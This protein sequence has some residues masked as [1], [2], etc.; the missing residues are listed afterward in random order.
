MIGT[1]AAL[2]AGIVGTVGKMVERARANRELEKLKQSLKENPL[3]AQ[4]YAL[5]QSMFGAQAPGTQ[6]F[7]R[8][9]ERS[10]ASQIAAAERA[11]ENPLLTAA[12]AGA[13]ANEAMQNIAA[14]QAAYKTSQYGN[15]AQA[16]MNLAQEQERVFKERA[17]I[18]AMKQENRYNTWGDIANIGYGVANFSAQGGF[19]KG[20]ST[21]SA[22]D[23]TAPLGTTTA[24][25]SS[26]APGYARP[27]FLNYNAMGTSGSR[28]YGNMQ[29]PS[30]INLGMGAYIPANTMTM[31]YNMF[32]PTRKF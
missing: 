18:D 1:I 24:G 12:A 27:S 6:E 32:N 11:G 8:G 22:I 28:S 7:I 31:G 4:Q 26:Y 25:G 9:V 30:F 29:S 15:V 3:Y 13:Q 19:G 23:R 16:G 10:R 20:P 21:S 14:Q 2:G 17:E 5:A